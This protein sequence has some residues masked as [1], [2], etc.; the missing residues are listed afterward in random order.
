MPGNFAS[1]A[2]LRALIDGPARPAS[3]G[4]LALATVLL[5]GCAF[6][7]QD[8]APPAPAP[9]AVNEAP[10]PIEVVQPAAP[11]PPPEPSPAPKPP[12]EPVLA[13]E[14]A[15]T[16]IL[17]SQDIPALSEI[18]VLIQ[19]QLGA[20][21]TSIHDLNGSPVNTSRILAEIEQTRPD[22]LVAIGLLAATVAQQVEDT[23]MI[24][25]QVYN[26]RDHDLISPNSKGVNMLPPFRMQLEAWKALAP[27]LQSIGVLT[28]PD[29]DD[30]IAEMGLAAAALDIDLTVRNVQS[31]KET[32][33]AF[34]RLT[35]DIQGVWLL[36]DNRI[37]SPEVVREI[38]SYSAKHRKQ[39]VVFGSELLGWGALMSIASDDGDIA[40]RVVA[41]LQNDLRDGQLAGPDMLPLGNM[42]TTI[43]HEV[44]NHLGLIVPQQ[45]ADTHAAR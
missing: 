1:H 27:N 5:G 6:V 33:F 30:L 21:H 43:N 8:I 44:A 36:P 25:C 31:D 10:A 12:P 20:E 40:R 4:F 19:Q 42:H 11:A 39:V 37:L 18:A 2:Q 9:V 45:F 15:H 3:R 14:P 29:Q 32:L 41:R 24:F 7:A 26:H 13:V 17:L 28:G 34:K 35:P 22:R 23:P 16:A 38:M